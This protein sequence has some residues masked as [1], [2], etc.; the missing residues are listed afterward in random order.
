M[1]N[2]NLNA[3]QLQ[4]SNLGIAIRGRVGLNSRRE[5]RVA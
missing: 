2:L 4:N 5:N 3:Q 1:A